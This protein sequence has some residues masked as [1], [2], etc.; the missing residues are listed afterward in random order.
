[1]GC[2]S[3][4]TFGAES[5]RIRM[6]SAGADGLHSRRHAS[7]AIPYAIVGAGIGGL[8]VAIA[9]RCALLEAIGLDAITFGSKV[10]G[11]TADGDRVVVRTASGDTAEGDLLIGADRVGSVIRR[12][13]HPSEPPRGRACP[14]ARARWRA[15][16]TSRSRSGVW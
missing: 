8:A 6:K 1:M 15:T 11:F 14:T 13:L 12:A 2:G 9:L 16:D 10:L 3:A 5:A 4:A 7:C